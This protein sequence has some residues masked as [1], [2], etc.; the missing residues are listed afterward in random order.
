MIPTGTLLTGSHD[1]LVVALCV[2]I[3]AAASYAALDLA[4]RVT[5]SK[6][7]SFAVWLTCGSLAM[8][9]GIWSMHFT[10]MLAFSLP[11]PVSYF[12]YV[13]AALAAAL[14]LF[15]VSRKEMS[16]SRAV[17]S[18]LVMGCGIAALHYMD[19]LAMRMPA[20]LIPSW[21]FCLLRLPSRS[22]TPH[23]AWHFIFEMRRK[24]PGEKSE[25]LS[26]RR[27]TAAQQNHSV[28]LL[29]L[30]QPSNVQPLNVTTIP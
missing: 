17:G 20:A 1:P 26:L 7:W 23:C 10:G 25:A 28:A 9:I 4:G 16:R 6:G 19:M 5:A 2:V 18:G 21:Q 15:V 24:L 8:G 29:F 14:A 27:S 3:A 11:V 12:S 22:P 13:V 30:P